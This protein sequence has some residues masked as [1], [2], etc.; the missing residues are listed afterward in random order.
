MR[1][2]LESRIEAAEKKYKGKLSL[3]MIKQLAEQDPTPTKKYLDRMCFWYSNGYTEEAIYQII[4]FFERLKNSPKLKEKDINKPIYDDMRKTKEIL[5]KATGIPPTP[6]AFIQTGIKKFNS[7]NWVEGNCVFIPLRSKEEAIYY[8]SAQRLLKD[9]EAKLNENGKWCISRPDEHNMYTS[10]TDITDAYYSSF[11]FVQSLTKIEDC[12]VFQFEFET[13]GYINIYFWDADNDDCT[14]DSIKHPVS[15]GSAKKTKMFSY[16]LGKI[17]EA[18]DFKLLRLYVD[19]LISTTLL[20]SN[21]KSIFTPHKPA[22][23]KIVADYADEEG[24]IEFLD[25]LVSDGVFTQKSVDV[26]VEKYIRS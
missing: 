20:I 19:E 4:D 26:F 7:I 9:K 3:A 22:I 23:L 8:G 14:I 1:L 11:V 13:Y 25:T 18:K 2:L 6:E 17:L 5:A 10:Y 24:A 16:M 12:G 21:T 15:I